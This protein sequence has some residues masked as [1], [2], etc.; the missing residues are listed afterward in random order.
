[1]DTNNKD[2][3][4]DILKEMTDW[5]NDELKTKSFIFGSEAQE[6]FT[7]EYRKLIANEI[8]KPWKRPNDEG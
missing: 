1:M 5:A 2:K 7:E 6:R 3:L 8:S 4:D